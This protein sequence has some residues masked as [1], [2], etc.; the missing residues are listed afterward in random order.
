MKRLLP[1]LFALPLFAIAVALSPA[2]AHAGSVGGINLSWADCGTAGTSNAS[3]TCL[4]NTGANVLIASFTPPVDINQFNGMAAVV[5]FTTDTNPMVAWWNLQAGGC[6]SGAMTGNFD[7]SG[8]PFTCNDVWAGSAVGAINID[9]PIPPAQGSSATAPT[10]N[11]AR[12]KVVCAIGTAPLAINTTTEYYVF[13]L[14]V[15]NAKTVGGACAGCL[16]KACIVFNDLLLTQPAG[17]GDYELTNPLNDRAPTWLG[18]G[19]DCASVPVRAATWGQIKSLY[20]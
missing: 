3:S 6:R 20:R 13:K 19:A 11:H 5:D 10:T 4:S 15:T 7:F 16:S 1:L 14:T 9:N 8:G 12:V 18:S 17:S 2:P